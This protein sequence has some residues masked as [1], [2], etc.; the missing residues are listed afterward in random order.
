MNDLL[1][2]EQMLRANTDFL[3]PD[4]PGYA[5]ASTAWN[6]AAVQRPFAVAVPRDVQSVVRVVRAAAGLGLRIAVQSTGHGAG[7]LAAGDL[8]RTVLLRMHE[9]TGVTVD[10]HART[11]RV[12][13]GTLWRDVIAAAAPH[14]LTAL[15]GSAGDVAVAGFVLGG[16]LSFYSRRHGLA[17]HSVRAFEV[18]TSSGEVIRATIDHHPK[19]FWALRGGGGNFG[20]VV[21]IELDLLQIP[22]VHAG[23]ML[24]DLDRAPEVLRAWRD[25]TV[26]LDDAITTS[27]RLM[28]FPAIP[29]L[30]P[31]LSGRRLVVI[32][33]AVLESDE[34][35]AELLGPLRALQP[36]MDTFAR[37]PSIGLLDVHMDPPVPTGGVSDH[38]LLDAL[39]DAAIEALLEVAGP[40]AEIPLM[41]AE[42][43]H[44]GGAAGVRQ[45]SGALARI[46]GSYAF[47]ALAAVPDH[48]L[49]PVA[50]ELTSA[51]TD[52]LRPWENGCRFLNFAER[53]VDAS[54]GFGG[55]AWETLD[56]VRT[57]YDPLRIWSAAHPVGEGAREAR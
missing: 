46:H 32:D 26:G 9:L 57:L 30:P 3:F 28:R 12:T 13:G 27:L 40:G 44:L 51:V 39:P 18:V 31:F 2:A 21:A 43:R 48:S 16:G 41:F 24:W 50:E 20:V 54:T 29:E 1:S 38:A 14:G 19:L 55:D 23:M 35:A 34:R 6:L 56:R 11:A 10:P 33:G 8:G 15:H 25:W 22:D 17:A 36:E 7:A 53:A 49:L 37:I 42:L 47:L 4:D 5:E 52:A 45:S